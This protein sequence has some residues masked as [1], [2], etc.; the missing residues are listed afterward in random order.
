MS[1][2]PIVKSL[3]HCSCQFWWVP[4]GSVRP[5]PPP[6]YRTLSRTCGITL[7]QNHSD[8]SQPP[9]A[10]LHRCLC[11]EASSVGGVVGSGLG[12]HFGTT[13]KTDWVCHHMLL[14]KRGGRRE[15]EKEKGKRGRCWCTTY[16]DLGSSSGF[17]YRQL[18][19]RLNFDITILKIYT[20]TTCI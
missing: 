5:H 11:T 10:R 2:S 6:H 15:S 16:R 17:I 9:P 4:G 19:L 8:L 12:T 3:C 7:G 20:Q 13:W 14:R 1:Q 18:H